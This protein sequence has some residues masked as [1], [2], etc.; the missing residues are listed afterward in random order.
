MA[1]DTECADVLLRHHQSGHVHHLTAHHVFRLLTDTGWPSCERHFIGDFGLRQL[2]VHRLY[3]L[4]PDG[5]A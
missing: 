1:H 2:L 4:R 3:G 5:A